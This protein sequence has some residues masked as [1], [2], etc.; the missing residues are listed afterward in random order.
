MTD[1]GSASRINHGLSNDVRYE[2]LSDGAVQVLNLRSQHTKLPGR[3]AKNKLGVAPLLPRSSS[4]RMDSALDLA[5]VVQKLVL[6]SF[7]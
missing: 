5:L 1:R 2:P 6:R 3:L 7:D 4:Q